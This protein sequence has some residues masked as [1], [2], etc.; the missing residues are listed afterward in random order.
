M[1]KTCAIEP[2]PHIHVQFY[3]RKHNIVQPRAN[4]LLIVFGLIAHLSIFMLNKYTFQH[5][6]G[7]IL[8]HDML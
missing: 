7:I 4:V 6:R 2:C 8:A 3:H 5:Q 1:H